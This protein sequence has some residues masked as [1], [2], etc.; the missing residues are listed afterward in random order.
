[1]KLEIYAVHDSAVG[2]F[3]QPLFFRSRGEAVRAFQDAVGKDANFVAHPDHF[4]FWLIGFYSDDNGRVEPIPEP[5]RVC[6]A[7]DF[8]A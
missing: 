7:R 6:G 2:A 5:E 4:S 8:V 3:N 1:M